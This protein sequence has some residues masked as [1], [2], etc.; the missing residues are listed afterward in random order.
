[1]ASIKTA[2]AAL[3]LL[4][5]PQSLGAS[6]LIPLTDRT[7]MLGWEAV[8]R[9]DIGGKGYC[10]G[11]LIANDLVLTAAHCVFD[12]SK[13]QLYGT[14]TFTFSAGFQDGNAI[15][16]RAI[17]QVVAHESYTAALGP[18]TTNIR[19][20]VALLK[21]ATPISAFTA[22]P[23][24]IHSGIKPGNIVSVV[25]YGKGRD[26]VLSWQKQ[27]DVLGRGKGLIAFNC[28]VTFGSSGAPVFVKEGNRARIVSLVSSGRNANGETVAFGMDLPDNIA[29][30]K[31]AMRAAPKKSTGS[32]TRISVGSGRQNTSAKFIK[33]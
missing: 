14:E 31:Q 29:D 5:S 23:F 17:K 33:N 19:H 11:V 20:D 9:I 8:G 7:D 2:L 1:M 13:N 15:E 3:L 27:C 28:D 24:A 4:L 6:G 10:T 32:I 12:K 18:I 30:L 22:A 25:S 21:L 16:S 26:D